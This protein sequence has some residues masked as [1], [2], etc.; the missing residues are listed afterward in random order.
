MNGNLHYFFWREYDNSTDNDLLTSWSLPISE[1]ED[2]W[3]QLKVVSGIQFFDMETTYPGL[4][5]GLGYPHSKT[6]KNDTGYVETGFSFD[7]TTGAPIIPGSSIKGALRS[8]FKT[9][10]EYIVDKLKT[11]GKKLPDS[12]IYTVYTELQTAL[13]EPEGKG[14]EQD[15]FFD[16]LPVPKNGIKP[17]ELDNITPHI[18]KKMSGQIAIVNALRSNTSKTNI[19]RLVLNNV[20]ENPI[21]ITILKVGANVEFRFAFLLH[22]TS[23]AGIEITKKDKEE[24]FKSILEDFGVGAKT[25]VGYGRMRPIEE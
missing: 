13:F 12:A 23:I 5:T 16:A 8:A 10:P 19:E 11:C 3:K 9:N 17:M 4:I 6:D 25:N 15:C 21:P 14:H 22:D 20:S 7:Y 2:Y 1:L 18:R 24:L